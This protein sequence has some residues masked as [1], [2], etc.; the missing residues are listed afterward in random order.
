MLLSPEELQ[1]LR[2]HL[3][4]CLHGPPDPQ[5]T[6]NESDC[7]TDWKFG[8]KERSSHDFCTCMNTPNSNFDYNINSKQIHSACCSDICDGL[9]T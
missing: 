9:S 8:M 6:T 4:R 5:S 7:V 3:A 1:P 2:L